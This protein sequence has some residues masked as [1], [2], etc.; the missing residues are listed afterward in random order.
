M[1]TS[2]LEHVPDFLLDAKQL[3]TSWSVADT[4]LLMSEFPLYVGSKMDF[5]QLLSKQLSIGIFKNWKDVFLKSVLQQI[6]CPLGS[7]SSQVI[8]PSFPAVTQGWSW[9]ILLTHPGESTPAHFVE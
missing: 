1:V 5:A 6:T 2:P 4:E 9:T 7:G 3:E 8:I